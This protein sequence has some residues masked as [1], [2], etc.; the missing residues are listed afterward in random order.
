MR[1]SGYSIAPEPAIPG[2]HAV[3]SDAASHY[4]LFAGG[5]IFSS[6]QRVPM[7]DQRR[8]AIA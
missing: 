1:I 6:S 5:L 3:S 8:A 2:R 7:A 4:R